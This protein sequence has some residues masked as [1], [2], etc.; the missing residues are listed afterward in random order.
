VGSDF[1][2]DRVGRHDDDRPGRGRVERARDQRAAVE[3]LEQLLPP[4]AAGCTR[5]QDDDR[6]APTATRV[7]IGPEP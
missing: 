1:A 5:R 7:R 4:E 6:Q 2:G 3:R